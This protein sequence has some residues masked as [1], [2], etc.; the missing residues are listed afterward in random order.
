MDKLVVTSREELIKIINAFPVDANLNH[1]DVKNTP[2]RQ[3]RSVLFFF[4]AK[5]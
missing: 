5:N 4:L 2:P 3:G 1:L